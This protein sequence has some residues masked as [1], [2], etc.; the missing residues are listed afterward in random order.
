MSSD[1]LAY[2][3]RK[4]TAQ[5]RLISVK[6]KNNSLVYTKFQDV[7]NKTFSEALTNR[8]QAIYDS[9][10]P[11]CRIFLSSKVKLS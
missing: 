5:A 11:R 1:K 3:C 8:E 4:K 2:G 7:T 9:L 6:K 10:P